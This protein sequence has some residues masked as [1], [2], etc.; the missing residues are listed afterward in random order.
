MSVL[1]SKKKAPSNIYLYPIRNQ[2]R[3]VPFDFNA[4]FK[5]LICLLGGTGHTQGIPLD[6]AGLTGP[7]NIGPHLAEGFCN[8]KAI[9]KNRIKEQV[10]T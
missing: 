1:E 7:M 6:H 10:C 4:P 8:G 2:E 3:Q 9:P 5:K